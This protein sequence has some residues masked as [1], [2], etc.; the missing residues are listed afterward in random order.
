MSLLD[1]LNIASDK[2]ST[3]VTAIQFV[4]NLSTQTPVKM[5]SEDKLKAALT[6][7][8][9]L[10]PTVGAI[11]GVISVL[12]GLFNT[13]GLFSKHTSSSTEAPHQNV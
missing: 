13:L 3:A 4:E 6:V 2:L 10:N 5:T 12:V 11:E 1:K 7:V 8:G 9:A